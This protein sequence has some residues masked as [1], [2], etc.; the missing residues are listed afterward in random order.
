M[1]SV[2]GTEINSQ[3]ASEELVVDDL[4][5]SDDEAFVTYEIAAYPADYTLSVLAAMW[6][7]K[8]IL[9][10]KFQRNFVW[11]IR[12][13][14]LLIES[15]LMGLPVP[16]AFFFVEADGK[17]LVIDG[18][19][20]RLVSQHRERIISRPRGLLSTTHTQHCCMRRVLPEHRLAD[21]LP[22]W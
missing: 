1:T 12:Q 18:R 3:A 16:Q 21:S 4:V 19:F 8:D 7:E 20:S 9:V 10:P 6:D 15:L 11:T 2:D 14:S 17:Y 22:S 13:A 5:I